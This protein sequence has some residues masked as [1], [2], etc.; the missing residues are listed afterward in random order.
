MKKGLCLFMIHSR[1]TRQISFKIDRITKQIHRTNCEYMNP[2]W[3]SY[4]RKKMMGLYIYILA[5]VLK[6]NIV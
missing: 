6:C 1:Y 5:A 2:Q 3:S 4:P